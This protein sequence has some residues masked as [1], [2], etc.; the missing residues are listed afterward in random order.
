M[1]PDAISASGPSLSSLSHFVGERPLRCRIAP[2]A[3]ACT[4]ARRRI[5][6][7]GGM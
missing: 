5:P 7:S 4:H 6:A 1:R 2:C 3:S